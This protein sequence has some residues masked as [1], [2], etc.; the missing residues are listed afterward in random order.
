MEATTYV[1]ARKLRVEER[2]MGEKPEDLDL[3]GLG[4]AM[5]ERT[6]SVIWYRMYVARERVGNEV[7][8]W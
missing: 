1:F 6:K 5:L 3:A 8:E 4:W 7:L 2:E